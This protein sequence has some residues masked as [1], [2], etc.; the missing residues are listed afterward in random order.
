MGEAAEPAARS[1]TRWFMWPFAAL[2]VAT[3]IAIIWLAVELSGVFPVHQPAIVAADHAADEALEVG[4][5]TPLAG[6]SLIAIEIRA[7]GNGRNSMAYS[8][9]AYGNDTRNL[10]FLDRKTGTSRRVMAT[11]ATR[12]GDIEYLPAAPQGA[13]H[14]SQEVGAE[15]DGD[16][17]NAP[18]AYYL[19]TVEHKLNN[20]DSV[21]DLLVGTLATGKQAIVM[22]GLSGLDQSGMIDATRLGVVVREGKA[23]Y[24]R[25]IDVPALKQI[26]SHKIEI[27]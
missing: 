8:G 21:Y 4:S 12:I 19:M 24:Y 14:P 13:S 17:P 27:G 20:G 7:V 15:D 26:E 2:G 16:A 10:L 23:L 25:V 11:N 5:V 1:R 22:S 9:S 3:A 6:T 18:P